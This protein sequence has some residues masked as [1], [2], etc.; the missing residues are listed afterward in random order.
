MGS[1]PAPAT[2]AEDNQTE[3]AATG[4]VALARAT[5]P[6][7]LLFKGEVDLKEVVDGLNK[8]GASS[9]DLVQVLKI[10]KSAGALHADLEIR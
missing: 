1:E 4:R 8:I 3:G 10:I 6:A 9:T 5:T 2:Q 7:I